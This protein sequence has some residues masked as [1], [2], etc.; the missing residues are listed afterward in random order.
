[1]PTI[2]AGLATF[3]FV[4]AMLPPKAA[5]LL[6]FDG[7]VALHVLLGDLM[8][9][10]GGL[11][12]TEPTN[13][14]VP[15]KPFIAHEWLAQVAFARA[16]AALGWAGPLG[17]CALAWSATLGLLWARMRWAGAAV[18]PA[19]IVLLPTIAVVHTHLNARPHVITWLFM[20]LLVEGVE[21]I[22][23]GTLSP[24]QWLTLA[25]P[26]MLLWSNVHA[27]FLAVVP[28]LGLYAVGALVD[29]VSP[30]PRNFP[31]RC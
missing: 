19:V 1:M 9:S 24:W 10:Q 31:R 16:H 27:G 18:W 8:W 28:V 7:D 12:E 21:R 25:L 17:I 4:V 26:L 2:G 5:V 30:P 15:A 29:A 3:A 6:S 23:R 20:S 13:F 14:A 22:R 11:L